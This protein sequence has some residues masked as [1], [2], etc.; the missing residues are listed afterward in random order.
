VS[1]THNDDEDILTNHKT[2]DPVNDIDMQEPELVGCILSD[3]L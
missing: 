1:G 3:L 2:S